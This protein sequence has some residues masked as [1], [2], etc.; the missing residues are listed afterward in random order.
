MFGVRA[1]AASC[2]DIITIGKGFG[3]GFPVSGL[4]STDEIAQAPSR[5]AAARARRRATAATRWPPR[6]SLPRSS[7]HRRGALVEN[8]AR[9]GAICC[10][11]FAELQEKY[12]FIGD[13]R[14]QGLL[15]GVD[16]VKDRATQGAARARTSACGSSRLRSGAAWSRWC[17]CPR[18][19]INPPLTIDR[20]RPR[21]EALG[22]LDEVFA[23]LAREGGWR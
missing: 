14:G 7:D 5:G 22:I 11:R 13:V 2:P 12:E 17:Y 18:V 10:A 1:L 8:A 6:R 3:G 20:G 21:D 15:I 19:R 16:L 23:E 4:V 9:V